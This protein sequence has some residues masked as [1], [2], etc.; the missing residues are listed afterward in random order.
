MGNS[1]G[2]IEKA[3]LDGKNVIVTGANTGK[4]NLVK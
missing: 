4:N 2:A 3:N 1:H